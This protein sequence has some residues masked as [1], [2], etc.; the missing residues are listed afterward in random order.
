MFFGWLFADYRTTMLLLG[1]V[2]LFG[3]AWDVLYHF[4]QGYRWDGDW[5]PVYQFFGGIAEGLLIWLLIISGGL[6]GIGKDMFFHRF[7]THYP[8]V[9]LV[10]FILSQGALKILFPRWR[11]HGGERM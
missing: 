5:P 8:A 1:Y 6:P 9:W 7:I 10:T 4:L 11:F 2:L 3:F